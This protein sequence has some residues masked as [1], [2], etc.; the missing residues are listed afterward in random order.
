MA[1]RVPRPDHLFIGNHTYEVLWLTHEEWEAERLDPEADAVTYARRNQIFIRLAVA[2][3]SH[4]QEVL[5][6]EI[7]H[8]VWDATMLTHADLSK[9]DDPEEFVIGI[10]SPPMVFVLKQ[11]PHF[12]KWLMSDG[13][14]AR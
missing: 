10:Q 7:A 14:V 6:H 11:N 5:W 4:Y 3:E 13:A 8:A 9:Q 12:T 2:H 1:A